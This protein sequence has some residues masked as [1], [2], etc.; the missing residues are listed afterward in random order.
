MQAA[1]KQMALPLLWFSLSTPIGKQVSIGLSVF[2][3]LWA[4]FLCYLAFGK[5]PQSSKD[6]V[7]RWVAGFGSVTLVFYMYDWIKKLVEIINSGIGL[8]YFYLFYSIGLIVIAVIMTY[9]FARLFVRLRK[10]IKAD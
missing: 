3:I 1:S 8:W 6:M 4:L 9:P 5:I 2:L 10:K 7:Y